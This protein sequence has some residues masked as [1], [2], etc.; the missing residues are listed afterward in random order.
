[1]VTRPLG[2]GIIGTGTIGNLHALTYSRLPHA[3][4]VAVCDLNSE[5]AESTAKEYRA[6]AYTDYRD[7]LEHPEVEAV[8]VVTPDFAHHDIA[9]ACANAGKHLLVEKPLATTAQEAQE[10]VDAAKDAGV[11]L[12]VNFHNRFNPPFVNAK[13]KITSGELG[14]L[15]YIYARLSNTAFVPEKMLAWSNQSS[16]LWF[17]AS[18][19]LDLACW[20]LDA[21]PERV[22][23]VSRSGT[24]KRKGIDTEDF[25][26]AIVEF[27]DGAV[28]TLENAWILPESEP[29]VYNFKMEILGNDGSIYVNT[30]DHRM[31]ALYTSEGETLPDMLGILPTSPSRVSGFMLE[32][33]AQFVD[34]VVEDTPIP[35]SGQDGLLNTR[36]LEAIAASAKLSIPVELSGDAGK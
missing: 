8:S 25:Y 5:R 33:I 13:Q 22:Y 3:K 11:K 4:L 1:M 7:L 19:T 30:S 34:A 2:T 20:L 16:S 32:P 28:V 18:H 29:M 26:I 23:A 36:T 14:S 17:L 12:M 9:I 6:K 27:D 15:R 24:L 31:L 21:K 35:I 10:I